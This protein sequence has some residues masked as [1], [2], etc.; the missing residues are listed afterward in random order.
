LRIP[1]LVSF[2]GCDA[3]LLLLR[4]NLW[5]DLYRELWRD[6]ANVVALSD[7]MR[8]R[9]VKLECPP[10]KIEVVHLAKRLKDYPWS[11]RTPPLRRFV[12]VGRL[13][14]KKGHDDA[15]RALGRVRGDFPG[16]SLRII[17][18]GPERPALE[19]LVSELSLS[20]SVTVTGAL[21]HLEVI[22]E[23][24]AADGMILA[25]KTPPDGDQEGTPTVLLE[26]QALGLPV[27]STRHAGIPETIPPTSHDTLAAEDDVESLV[28]ALRKLLEVPPAEL[29]ARTRAARTL[30]EE[31][32]DIAKEARKLGELYSRARRE[33]SHSSHRGD[34]L[35]PPRSDRRYYHLR[36]LA[37]EL[38]HLSRVLPL[39]PETTLLDFGCGEMPYRALFQPRVGE[40]LGADIDGNELAAIRIGPD[41]T[42]PL[43]D[44]SVDVV[45][46]SQVLEHVPRPDAYLHEAHRVLTSEGLL[47]L[48]T[49]GRWRYHPDP[50]D[51]WRWTAEGLKRLLEEH[52]FE[53]LRF[54]GLM[55]PLASATQL[56][57]DAAQLLLPGRLRPLFFRSMQRLMEIED[58]LTPETV[59]IHDACVY[60]VVCRKRALEATPA[61]PDVRRGRGRE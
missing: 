26:A 12:S 43:S 15:V 16:I 3:N 5:L 53:L 50:V 17:G 42:L 57:Q 18:E 7:E 44:E 41:G 1:L 40:Y 10:G 8:R 45:L 30:I 35:T 2:Y 28:W 51:L 36:L 13:V 32:F 55:G 14:P 46:S 19:S 39:G 61:E 6:A 48:S 9:L 23:M 4:D 31:Q 25:S 37:D 20:G 49:H 21:P 27:V 22:D 59:R 33:A 60:V 56:W 11:V 58:F 29:T 54:K 52:G 47:V 34:R 24:S 38:G